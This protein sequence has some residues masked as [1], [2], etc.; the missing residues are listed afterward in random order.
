MIDTEE[1]IGRLSADRGSEYE[2]SQNPT[3]AEIRE[4]VRELKSEGLCGRRVAEQRLG[5]YFLGNDHYGQRELDL[6]EEIVEEEYAD[7]D[8][9]IQTR[10]SE[11][12]RLRGGCKGSK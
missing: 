4:V 9:C 10:S 1:F 11:C 7:M 5:P 12:S 6:L 2:F 3:E 8:V